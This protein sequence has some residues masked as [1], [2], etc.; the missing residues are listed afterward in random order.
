MIVKFSFQAPFAL[1]QRRLLK[2]FIPSIFEKEHKVF[3]ELTIVF[4][5]AEFLLDINNRFL[6]HDYHTDIITFDMSENKNSIIGEI[7]VSVDMVRSNARIYRTPISKEISR[8]IF[9][10]VL[11]LCGFKDKSASQKKLM[12]EKEDFYLGMYFG[13]DVP[14][15]TKT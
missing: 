15:G 5:N 1:R 12:R 3:E 13:I 11:H 7:Y 14:R 6:S 2:A 4:C 9:H 10:G 8:V